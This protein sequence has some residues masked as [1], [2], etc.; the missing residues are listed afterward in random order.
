ME[1]T[2][3]FCLAGLWATF[4]ESAEVARLD[5]ALFSRFADDRRSEAEVE[6]DARSAF[7]DDPRSAVV[8]DSFPEAEAEEATGAEG[9]AEVGVTAGV[10]AE[11]DAE[12]VRAEAADGESDGVP[13]GEAPGATAAE[14]PT[15]AVWGESPFATAA[16][17]VVDAA[18]STAAPA[19]TVVQRRLPGA[20]RRPSGFLPDGLVEC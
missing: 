5:V 10:D 6:V 1:T 18:A 15:A 14:R 17:A 3:A 9:E 20:V 16:H 11:G 8:V 4:E 2:R 13:V 7:E 19:A 12:V